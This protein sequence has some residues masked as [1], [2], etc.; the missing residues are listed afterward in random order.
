MNSL[1]PAVFVVPCLFLSQVEAGYGG[2]D[3]PECHEAS[4]D[5]TEDH[6]AQRAKYLAEGLV[7]PAAGF[8]R[9]YVEGK[10]V[11]AKHAR[12]ATPTL[13]QLAVGHE[14]FA[15]ELAL[16][17]ALLGA[18]REE[19]LIQSIDVQYGGHLLAIEHNEATAE[20]VN[21]WRSQNVEDT[22]RGPMKRYK[23]GERVPSA[24]V[25]NV[26]GTA[27]DARSIWVSLTVILEEQYVCGLEFR[28]SRTF[29]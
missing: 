15:A 27:S 22:Y 10:W 18:M 16:R 21:A 5:L 12:P 9:S 17:E 19:P 4:K 6:A 2:S 13:E 8:I 14:G 7:R 25:T 20:S 3:R 1:L 11:T 23:F 24:K 29:P 26:V 28:F